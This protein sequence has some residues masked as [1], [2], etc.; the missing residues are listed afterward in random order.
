MLQYQIAEDTVTLT[1]SEALM[2]FDQLWPRIEQLRREYFYTSRKD[3]YRRRETETL[4]K[5]LDILCLVLLIPGAE[6]KFASETIIEKRSMGEYLAGGNSPNVQIMSHNVARWIADYYREII[7]DR[8]LEV[9]QELDGGQDYLKA[10]LAHMKKKFQPYFK[11]WLLFR[12]MKPIQMGRDDDN[13]ESAEG[14]PDVKELASMRIKTIVGK[15][16]LAAW[17]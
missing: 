3:K 9:A 12:D 16:E 5:H 7:T 6:I 14:E 1:P 10:M 8:L 4:I 17:F 11:P 13:E 15:D 2:I